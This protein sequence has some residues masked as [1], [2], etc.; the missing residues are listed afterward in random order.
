MDGRNAIFR[1]VPLHFCERVL[2][3]ENLANLVVTATEISQ[4]LPI[5]L[6]IIYTLLPGYQERIR[7][8]AGEV[9][10]DRLKRAKLATSAPS[11]SA[12]PSMQ[13][14]ASE[15]SRWP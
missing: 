15:D 9:F 14:I 6:F 11:T 4:F 2:Q 3:T 1:N 12:Q 7:R 13:G 10:F 8:M 5:I